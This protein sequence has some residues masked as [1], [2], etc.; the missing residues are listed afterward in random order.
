[1]VHWY[2]PD[3]QPNEAAT[4]KQPELRFGGIVDTL[5]DLN[6]PE[7]AFALQKE[8]TGYEGPGRNETLIRHNGL[9]VPT[10]QAFRD[11]V[12]GILTINSGYPHWP[13][14]R[15]L[16]T[17]ITE[18]IVAPH[19]K[20][21]PLYPSTGQFQDIFTDRGNPP[22]SEGDIIRKEFGSNCTFIGVNAYTPD[23][24][25]TSVTGPV[26][27]RSS[28]SLFRRAL[29]YSETHEAIARHPGE[30]CFF[31]IPDFALIPDSSLILNWIDFEENEY[32]FMELNRTHY[33]IEF[34]SPRTLES[35]ILNQVGISLPNG[36]AHKEFI[37]T[38]GGNYI[39]WNHA[40]NTV[41]GSLPSTIGYNGIVE[42]TCFPVQLEEPSDNGHTYSVRYWFNFSH[43]NM[44]TVLS[45]YSK[46]FSLLV[47]ADLFNDYS[48]SNSYLD[49]NEKYT[50]FVPSEEALDN[51][52]VDTL[53]K[54]E[55]S[56]FLKYHFLIGSLIFTDNKQPSG[57][58]L[59]TS[60]ELLNI[61][62]GPDYIEILDD[63]GN[64]YVLVQ[65]KENS[66]NIMASERSAVS[67]VVHEIDHV[68]I[69]YQ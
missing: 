50:V 30:L 21:V 45:R 47:Q 57:A 43:I 25:F 60:G 56:E 17:D 3:F 4:N 51:Y 48:Y 55:L 62:T 38:M 27:L 5:W 13:D 66:N 31:P 59:T 68:L 24:V 2:Y 34:L 16:P 22:L 19:F 14:H 23:P 9:Y 37:E 28:Y 53:D 10:D 44:G 41:R 61:Q 40:D 49:R 69:P 58:Y 36:S 64:P 18:I 65:E 52:Q 29:L 8:S 1:M 35:R 12:D 11:F 67:G 63:S 39:I 33:G 32:N 42:K 15:S 6:Y 7:L 54:E 20:S 46:F 26:F